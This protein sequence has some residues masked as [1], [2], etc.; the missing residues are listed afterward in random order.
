MTGT[1]IS[2]SV[3][4]MYT[5]QRYLQFDRLKELGLGHFD[6]WAAQFGDTVTAL[7]MKPSGEG[8]REF[9]RFA[10]FNNVPELMRTFMEV[11]DLQMD[12]D[13]LGLERPKLAGDKAIGV[14]APPTPELKAFIQDCARRADSLGSVRPDE[15]NMLKIVNDANKAALDMRLIDPSLPDNPN[16]KVNMAIA[17][18]V[19]VYRD[20]TGVTLAGHDGPQNMAQMVF[21]D[22]STP[23]EKGKGFSVYDDMKQKLIAAGVPEHEIA[24]IHDAE[25]DEAKLELFDKVNAGQVRFLFGSTGKMGSGTNAQRR[26]AALHHIDAPWRPSDVEQREGRILRQG[27]LNKQVK[28]YRYATEESFDVYKWQLLQSKAKFI[29]Q[30]MSG[31][32]ESRSIE[33]MDQI[34]LGYAEMKALATGNPVIIERIK[35]EGE[36]R[37]Y[38]A[39][40]KA[41]RDKVFGLQRSIQLA[42]ED[43]PI[44]ERMA[45]QCDAAAA[46]VATLPK[47]FSVRIGNR[48]YGQSERKEAGEAY[49]AACDRV[50]GTHTTMELGTFQGCPIHVSGNGPDKAPSVSIEITPEA[51][52]T[53]TPSVSATGNMTILE[54]T[55][56][57]PVTDAAEHRQRAADLQARI[58][59]ETA[60]MN[61]PFEHADTLTRLAGRLAELD[62]QID[63]IAK[64]QPAQVAG[65]EEK[66]GAEDEE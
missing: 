22:T 65:D 20:T 52:Y 59:A 14:S 50:R 23:K 41:H 46:K 31:N 53:V 25:G 42:K 64:G 2:N 7:E 48:T 6:A 47:E 30:V 58:V 24:F 37:K 55:L 21:L 5:M 29:G 11:A 3:G 19:Q 43:I 38:V 34:T 51:R 66:A 60:E 8:Y 57:K 44:R 13:A 15:D 26:L 28:V 1:P 49:M 9:T 32:L 61:K 35:T 62:A 4:E 45:A 54:H 27:N 17:N 56:N 36:L 40:Q 10:K 12:P 63:G 33:D 39:L 18:M 16:S